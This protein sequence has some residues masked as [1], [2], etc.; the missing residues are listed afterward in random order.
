MIPFLSNDLN[1]VSGEEM[2]NIYQQIST[3]Y[4]YGAVMKLPDD[5]TDSPSVFYHDGKWYMYF[6]SISKNSGV[7]GYE[8]HLAVSNN[9]LD[10]KITDTI[11]RRDNKNNWDSK[12]CAG[13]AAFMDI[14][15]GGS[16]AITSVNGKYY[17]SYLAGN[18]DGYEPDPLYMGLACADQ[19]VH[20]FKRFPAPI[21]RPDDADAREYETKTLYRSFLFED[22]AR[23]TG[24]RYVNIYNGKAQDNRERIFAAV[25]NDAEHWERYGDR[26]IIDDASDQP[27]NL[28][29]GDAQ[30]EK[31]G[32]IYVMFYFRLLDG[33]A[34]DTF[35]ASR[36]LVH[37][38]KWTGAPLVEP[39]EAW[40]DLYAHKPWVIRHDGVVYHY[41]CACNRK[42]ERF[43]ALAASKQIPNK[44][45]TV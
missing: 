4:K 29:S 27:G 41:Y 45:E 26:A 20:P 14:Q 33:K 13:Y 24:F 1:Q 16:N 34:F 17:I 6:I 19:P 38:T 8:T 10:W 25:S 43:I 28:I 21:L 22:E 2:K 31:I 42:G 3:P 7:S 36:D 39:T 40:D 15:W 44:G 18:S 23:I 32:D 35:A 30:I 5:W 11:F 9:L 37:W 12:Q